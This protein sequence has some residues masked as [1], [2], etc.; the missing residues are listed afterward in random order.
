[1]GGGFCSINKEQGCKSKAKYLAYQ[2][3]MSQKTPS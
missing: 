2:K 3:N 1:M